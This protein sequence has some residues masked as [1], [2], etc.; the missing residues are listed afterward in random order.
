MEQGERG[1]THLEGGA[2]EAGGWG[3]GGAPEE[4]DGKADT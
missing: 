4:G 2:R 3:G 1:K